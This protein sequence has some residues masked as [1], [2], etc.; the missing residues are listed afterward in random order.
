MLFLLK[1]MLIVA[2]VLGQL[3]DTA[4]ETAKYEVA[5]DG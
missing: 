3:R 4:V 5:H 2:P 1:I